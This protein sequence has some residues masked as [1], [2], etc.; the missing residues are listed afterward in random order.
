MLETPCFSLKFSH[1]IN[2][3]DIPG[4]F[5]VR[6]GSAG[7]TGGDLVGVLSCVAGAL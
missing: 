2:K 4:G 3:G 5:M 7:L 1:K 6:G